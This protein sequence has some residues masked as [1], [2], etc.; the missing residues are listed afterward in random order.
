LTHFLQAG[1]LQELGKKSGPKV[2]DAE[3][4]MPPHWISICQQ[5]THCLQIQTAEE[6]LLIKVDDSLMLDAALRNML[7]LVALQSPSAV[8]QNAGLC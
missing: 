5:E 4:L 2:D 3:S 8:G 6:N 7:G 1:F